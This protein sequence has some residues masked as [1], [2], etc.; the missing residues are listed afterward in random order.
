MLYIIVSSTHV[1]SSEFT[2]V[3]STRY[4]NALIANHYSLSVCDHIIIWENDFTRPDDRA[5]DKAWRS[6]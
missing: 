2:R 1:I 3:I 4:V 6:V 5:P